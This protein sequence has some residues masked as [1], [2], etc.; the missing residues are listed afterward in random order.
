M[1]V[2]RLRCA[3]DRCGFGRFPL[4]QAFVASQN[5]VFFSNFCQI[6]VASFRNRVVACAEGISYIIILRKKAR[7]SLRHFVIAIDGPAASGKSTTARRVA[8]DLGFLHLDTGA[9]YR[10]VTLKAL[11]VGVNPADPDLLCNI[12]RQTHVSLKKTD[13]VLTV[14][15]DGE[16]VTREIRGRLVTRSVS[17]VSSV[18][19]VREALVRE[20]RRAAEDADVVA[21]GRDI[22][23][24]VFPDAQLKFFMVAS[25]ES[26]AKRRLSELHGSGS[27]PSLEELKADIERRDSIDSTREESPLRKAP[28][29]VTID[30]SGLTI[31][32]Q[33]AVVV[34]EA[35]TRLKADRQA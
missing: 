17:A 12:V 24:V 9:M 18:R 15:L 28:D 21:E 4:F 25:I 23:T 27:A 29:A 32:E 22:G 6:D 1:R 33:V 31:E 8:G 3:L 14:F 35:R 2:E 5:I 20:Q 11:R 13:D 10:A 30:T 34:K 26:R 16:D 7:V 19:C